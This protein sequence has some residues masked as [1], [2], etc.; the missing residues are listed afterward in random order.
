MNLTKLEREGLEKALEINIEKLNAL[1][2]KYPV[3]T[4]ANIRFK[5]EH[6]IASAEK[7]IADLKGKIS[8]LYNIHVSEGETEIKRIIRSLE[9]TEPVGVVYLVNCDR[10]PEKK[11]FW[12]D[13]DKKNQHKHHFYFIGACDR[14]MPHS[15]AEY[16]VHELLEEE[17]DGVKDALLCRYKNNSQRIR[18]HELPAGRNLEK[19]KNEFKSFFVNFVRNSRETDTDSAAGSAAKPDVKPADFDMM[20]QSGVTGLEYDYAAIIF[21]LNSDTDYWKE[22]FPEYFEWLMDTFAGFKKGTRFLFFFVIYSKNLHEVTSPRVKDAIDSVEELAGRR[23]EASFIKPLKPVPVTDLEAWFKK[24]GEKNPAN[25]DRVLDAL[26]IGLQPAQQDI[27]REVRLLNMCDV[28]K[29]QKI[30]WEVANE[31]KQSTSQK[32]AL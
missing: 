16:M 11:R 24:L 31:S 20:L 27:P 26:E 15:F 17:L 8:A 1:R 19:S 4:D 18:I 10:A 2:K 25:V 5:L 29:V 28:E 21:E 32:Q 9:I 3:E 12:S 30:A 7:E 22:H 13:F 14:Q 6:D 23:P